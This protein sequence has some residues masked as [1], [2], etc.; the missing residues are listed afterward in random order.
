M[1]YPGVP[2]EVKLAN[3]RYQGFEFILDSGADCTV[4]PRFM[5]ILVGATLPDK[6]DAH[7]TGVAGVPT[8]CY[9]GALSLRLGV[10]EF[11]V[12]CLFTESDRTPP[13]LGR[14]DF[15]SLF[16]VTFN[17]SGSGCRITLNK[18]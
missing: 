6:P 3:G 18:R 1:F 11:Q 13:L 16:E 4:V 15:F 8:P 14:V 2:V 7:M 9:K 5:S 17:G 10:D 12:R